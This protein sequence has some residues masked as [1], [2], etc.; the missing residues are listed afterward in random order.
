MGDLS[1]RKIG[2][3]LDLSTSYLYMRGLHEMTESEK[4]DWLYAYAVDLENDDREKLERAE[5]ARK[6]KARHEV[7]Q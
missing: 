7:T 6:F 1:V 3:A 2:Q 5:L 4:L